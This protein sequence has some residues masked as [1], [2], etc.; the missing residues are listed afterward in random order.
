MEKIKLAIIGAGLRGRYTYGNFI[1]GNDDLCEV[2]AVVETKK[3]RRDIFKEKFSLSDEKVFDN[4]GSFFAEEK[5]ADAVIICNYDNMHFYTSTLALEKGYDVLVE[6]PVANS[7]DGLAHLNDICDKYRD[8]VFMAS[9]PFRYSSFFNKLKETIDSKE[10]GVLININYN[11]YIGYEKFAHNFVRGNWRIESDT[12]TLMLTNSCYDLDILSFLT[13]SNYKKISSFG[14]L[15]HFNRMNFDGNMSNVCSRCGYY[16]K[17]PY[18][19]QNI[20]LKEDK[21][22]NKSLH[23][24]PTKDNLKEILVNGPYGKCVYFCDNDVYDNVV[25]ILQFQNNITASL[26]I[27]AFTKE[28]RRNIRLMFSHGEVFADYEKNTISIHKFTDKDEQIVIIEKEDIDKKLIK[29]FIAKIKSRDTDN[30][31][32]SVKSCI[33]AHV[34]AFAGEFANISESIVNVDIFFEEAIQ[35]TKTIEGLIF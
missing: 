16:D 21:L 10:L 32:S 34:T 6:G 19:A 4:I 7:L 5:M 28:E 27:S 11:S 15:S 22:I 18:C 33:N 9:L 31:N 8:R 13:N 2:V 29:D 26:N 17:C 14:R 35:M 23:I 1:K 3:G 20:Y 30:I 12:A 24:D 25:S